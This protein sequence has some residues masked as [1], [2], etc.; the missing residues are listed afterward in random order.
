[1]QASQQRT[2]AILLLLAMFALGAHSAHAQSATATP[3]SA[4]PPTTGINDRFLDPEIDIQE[5]IDRFE[6][7]SREIFAQ[8][9]AICQAARIQAGMRIAVIGAGTGFFSRLFAKQTGPTGRVYAVDISPAFIRH[10]TELNEKL[11]LT[12]I[13][14][15]RCAED[16]VNLPAASVDLVFICDT[17]HHFEYPQQTMQSIHTALRPAGELV[18]IDFEREVGKSR[19]W[20]LGHVRAGKA[21]FRQEIEAAGFEFEDEV[22]IDGFHENYLLRFRKRAP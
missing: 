16:A 13:S 20:I 22:V 21:T 15:L 11:G 3:A 17:Y 19:E 12:N 14:P 2:R 5:W 6:G 8:R 4:E 18:L 9:E 10:I 1:M 7:E